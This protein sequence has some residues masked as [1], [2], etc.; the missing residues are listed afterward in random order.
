MRV[1]IG[2]RSCESKTK[3]EQ[4]VKYRGLYLNSGGAK[5]AFATPPPGLKLQHALS[6]DLANSLPSHICVVRDSQEVYKYIWQIRR[7]Y[8]RRR[9][10]TC[11][12]SALVTLR[13]PVDASFFLLLL[14]SFCFS[15]PYHLRACLY[16]SRYPFI[17]SCRVIL[18]ITYYTNK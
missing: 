4:R 12:R 14:F 11:E 2:G 7:N 18:H 17:V 3:G 8:I 16:L 6:R 13:P 9:V 10:Q 15:R 5:Q 1:Y